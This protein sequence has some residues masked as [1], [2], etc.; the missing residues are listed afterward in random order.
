MKVTVEDAVAQSGSK[1]A[2][3]DRSEHSVAGDTVSVEGSDICHSETIETLHDEHTLARQFGP[4]TR[5]PDRE[6]VE[7]RPHHLDVLELVQE[8]ELLAEPCREVLNQGH[9]V[10]GCE[11][12]DEAEA[13]A[14]GKAEDRDIDCEH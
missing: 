4:S 2:G 5:H 9:R 11:R 7:S 12:G 14:G 6:R 10:E 13:E 8:R 3:G 1:Q